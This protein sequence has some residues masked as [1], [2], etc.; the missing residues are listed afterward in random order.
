MA[1]AAAWLTRCPNAKHGL[2]VRHAFNMQLMRWRVPL[3]RLIGFGFILL[4][5]LVTGR[6]ASAQHMN[7]PDAPC[8]DVAVTTDLARCLNRALASADQ[9]LND[10][11]AR[12]QKVLAAR[13][14]S[15][16]SANL[17]RAERI[18]VQFR[19]ATWAA[20]RDLY[21]GGTAS[22]PA[23]LACLEAQTRQRNADLTATYG[24]I[25]EKFEK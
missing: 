6:N 17:V 15:T 18:W 8:G 10:T 16:D 12:I 4:L 13:D 3:K 7:A 25:L 5:I 19:D 1:L 20:E 21:G 14:R 11:Y 2:A 24:W 23:H 22:G 9:K